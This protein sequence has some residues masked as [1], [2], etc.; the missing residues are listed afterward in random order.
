MRADDNILSRIEHEA[1]LVAR[2]FGVSTPNDLAAMLL[3]RLCISLGGEAH[4][5][6]K[7][8]CSAMRATRDAQIARE[9]NGRNGAEL[10][11]QH[12]ITTRR[13]RQIAARGK[14]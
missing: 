14:K 1:V 8:V 4:Y 5:L 10:A 2:A 3:D 13:V 7:T 6:P 11:E 12:R 9:Y